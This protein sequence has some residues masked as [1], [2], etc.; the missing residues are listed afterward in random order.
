[1]K[2]FTLI[3]KDSPSRKT[4]FETIS[5]SSSIMSKWMKAGN[6]VQPTLQ[7]PARLDPQSPGQITLRA[8]FKSGE[9]GLNDDARTIYE[10]N[11][12]IF[13]IYPYTSH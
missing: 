5:Q 7:K 1:M 13:G 2:S 12:D 3:E 9:I 4:L 6:K 10:N 11:K 8:M